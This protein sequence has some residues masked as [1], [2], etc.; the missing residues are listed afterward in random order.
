MV[1]ARVTLN[2]PL[3]TP[4]YSCASPTLSISAP[5]RTLRPSAV[6]PIRVLPIVMRAAESRK[7]RSLPE[8]PRRSN[9][10]LFQS[11][12]PPAIMRTVEM[13]GVTSSAS[14]ASVPCN[15]CRPSLP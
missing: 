13:Y 1:S 5:L 6:R 9:G 15:V 12:E 4:P 10:C 8:R 11:R 7:S 2:D 14:A 3:A